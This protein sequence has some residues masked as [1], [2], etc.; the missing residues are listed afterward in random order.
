MNHSSTGVVVATFSRRMTLRLDDERVV[1]ARIKGK[2]LKPVCADRVIA[3]PIDNEDDWLIESIED[4]TNEL[5]R[6]DSRGRR[7][8]LASNLDTVVVVAGIQPKP[9]WYV[10][11]RYI[12]AA[13]NIEAG[14]IVV[15][16][17][18]DLPHDDEVLSVLED[19]RHC[20][21][22]VV[23]TSA[24]SG[25]G[26]RELAA[27]L[28]DRTAIIVGQSGVGKSSIINELIDDA[29]QRTAEISGSTGEGRHTTVNSVMLDLPESGRVI[30]S[31]GVRD[32]APAIDSVEDV[33]RGFR[34]ISEAGNHCRF[35]NCRHLQE[36]D[37]AVK[38]GVES[39]DIASRRY[40][41][42]K[43]LFNIARDYVARSTPGSLR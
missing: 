16:N 38:A 11:D 1:A 23:A 24:S 35:A 32:F 22:P 15:L 12:A 5:S 26:L 17:K 18:T 10:V 8:V 21:Y 13:E 2:K 36:P 19:Y 4:R 20:G 6:P 41:S 42:Y 14:A 30:D 3:S 29:R 25:E 34:E 31:P 7:E 33:I 43:R 39:G 37:C 9:D 28:K 40:D 27:M